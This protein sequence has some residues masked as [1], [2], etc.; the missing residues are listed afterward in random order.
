MKK[1]LQEV[2]FLVNTLKMQQSSLVGIRKS[3]LGGDTKY[4]SCYRS[5]HITIVNYSPQMFHYLD[6]SRIKAFFQNG[7]NAKFVRKEHIQNVCQMRDLL[8]LFLITIAK[9]T[10]NFLTLM[11][12]LNKN[13]ESSPKIRIKGRIL[14]RWLVVYPNKCDIFSRIICIFEKIIKR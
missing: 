9:T 8:I 3:Y 7:L 14:V 13:T 5:H 6:L 12:F 10:N 1:I 11:N 4:N 2:S